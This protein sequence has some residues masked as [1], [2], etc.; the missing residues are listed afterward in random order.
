M[1][2]F[3]SDSEATQLKW[4]AQQLKYH[5]TAVSSGLSF[6]SIPGSK[7]KLCSFLPVSSEQISLGLAAAVNGYEFLQVSGA[8]L[9][10][11]TNP[12]FVREL[13]KN[14]G[15][16]VLYVP[17]KE[18]TLEIVQANFPEMKAMKKSES[19]LKIADLPAL[20]YA[21]HTGLH[22]VKGMNRFRDML[23]YF[24]PVS[25]KAETTSTSAVFKVIDGS[26]RV[27]T[28]YGVEDLLQLGEKVGNAIGIRT[29]SEA[30][31]GN[32]DG[33]LEGIAA[34]TVSLQRNGIL[35]VKS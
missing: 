8:Q 5:V 3:D 10:A 11:E 26:G 12:T 33:E 6:L 34:A 22:T 17:G 14:F 16:N 1:L 20:K 19:L 28:E 7:P 21:V 29:D 23:T 25:N 2:R 30:V 35:I 24:A 27:K 32:A 18:E 9:A 15:V 13:M 4:N 31:Y